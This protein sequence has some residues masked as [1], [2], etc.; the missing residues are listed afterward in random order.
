M[1]RAD[2]LKANVG[3]FKEQGKALNDYASRDVKVCV[4]GNPANTNALIAMKYAPNIP[5][6][7]FSALTR[8]DQNRAVAMVADKAG[9]SVGKVRNII[10]WGNHSTTQYPDVTLGKIQ[11]PSGPCANV[12]DV[13]KDA[14]W[15]QG[16]FISAVQQRGGAVIAARKASS[17]ASAAKAITDHV[18]DWVHGTN[19]KWTSMA[20]LSNGEYGADKG[21]YFSFPVVCKNGNYEIVQGLQFDDFSKEKFDLSRKEL[22]SEKAAVEAQLPK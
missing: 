16:P 1:E 6:E 8:L 11:Q 9:V 15:L 19:G 18:R 14:E 12:T 5:R 17:A 4:V 7:N 10:I 20:V 22:L 13:V 21:L 3:I 2:L